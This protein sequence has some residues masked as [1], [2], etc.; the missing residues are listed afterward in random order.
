MYSLVN[1]NDLKFKI[2]NINK[3]KL[4]FLPTKLHKLDNLSQKYGVNI[5]IKRDDLIGFST[6]GGNK[7]RKLE[8][9]FGDILAQ[10]AKY[11]FTYGATQSNH[12]MQTAI[13]CRKYGLKPILYLV[14]VLNEE[15]DFPR[16][17]ML[18]DEIMEAEIKVIEMTEGEEEFDAMYRAKEES[19]KYAEE[20]AEKE[21]DYYLIPPGGASPIGTIGFINGYLEMKEQEFN[22]NINITDIFHPTGTGGTLGGLTAAHEY[23]NDD[24]NI[25]GI[26]VSHKDNSYLDEVAELANNALEVLGIESNVQREDIKVDNNYVGEGY[27]IPSNAANNAIKIFAK[28][29]GIFLDPVYTGKAASAL[30]DYIEKGKIEEGANVLFWH[31]GGTTGLFAEPKMLGNLLD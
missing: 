6:F 1:Y 25:H 14:D 4:G 10:E 8:Y 7:I 29:E 18:L 9:L 28:N 21:S 13:A 24:I 20:I 2:E 19:R 15:I 30:L 31:T 5:Y 23:L 16:A 22:Q 12:A 27:E 26:N 3:A 17:N 11:V